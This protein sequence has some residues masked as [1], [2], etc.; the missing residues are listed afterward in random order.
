MREEKLQ[1]DEETLSVCRKEGTK[2]MRFGAKPESGR[3]T[4]MMDTKKQSSG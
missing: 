4:K 2:G 3:A 1:V